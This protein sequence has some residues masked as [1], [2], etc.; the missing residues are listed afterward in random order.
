VALPVGTLSLVLHLPGGP[1]PVPCVVAC[2]GLR[3]SKDSDKYLSLGE[4]CTRSGLALARF[5]F[6]GSGE[7]EG[8]A[9]A[10]TTVASR[11]AD[12]L[13]VV[14][15]LRGRPRLDGR[16]GLLG[17]SMG[18][19]VALHARCALGD[20]I[21]VV[22]W[23]APASL[24]TL[25]ATVSLDATGLGAP[26]AAEFSTGRYALA[27]GG[28]DHHLVIQAEADET[29]PLDHGLALHA[30]ARDPRALFLLPA[31]DHRLTDAT[32]RRQAI[33]GSLAWLS[34]YLPLRAPASQAP[35]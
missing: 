1:A 17:S 13:A 5:D 21:P 4:E 26:F 27:P 35:A 7:S 23:N 11:V 32:H 24:A 9:E 8:L 20:S 34:R 19:F 14:T 2:H 10:E 15:F 29:V 3:A 22:T 33:A 25:A 12:V 6:R 30:Q 31:A 16:F 18:G 28:I